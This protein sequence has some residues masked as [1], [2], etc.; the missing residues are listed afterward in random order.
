MRKTILAFS[1]VVLAA[2]IASPAH[3]IGSSGLDGNTA[4]IGGTVNESLRVMVT[5]LKPAIDLPPLAF[6]L[7]D[8]VVSIDI[9]SA[10]DATAP[11]SPR[12]R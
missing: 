11:P 9:L 12:P 8:A 4:P 6:S 1:A 5:P 3:S 2:A 7:C 10:R